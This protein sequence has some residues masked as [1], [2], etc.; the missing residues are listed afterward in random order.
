MRPLT[1]VAPALLALAA[2]A[3][4]AQAPADAVGWGASAE[5]VQRRLV[6]RA[7]NGARLV[8][9]SGP[10][11]RL[12]VDG[13]LAL[14][15]GGALQ[16]KAWGAAGTL[17][18]DGQ[19][20]AGIPL[21]TDSRHRELGLDLAWRP[22]PAAS[23][24]QA[25]LVLR[26]LQQRRDIASTP[27]AVGLV[28]TSDYVM[29]GVRFSHAFDGGGWRWEPSL[30]LLA[31]VRHRLQVDSHGVFDEA[32]IRGG[33]RRELVLGL[34][35][36]APQSPWSLALAWSHARQSASPTQALSRNGTTVGT[37]RQPRVEIDDVGLRVRRAF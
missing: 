23:W 25:W 3:A 19:T 26:V 10:L 4:C 18:Y 20:Q 1:K 29:P 17:D 8:K 14:A 35:V 2:G 30:E 33:R 15:N 7:D 37:V 34:Q 12:A 21:T 32:D 31:S 13:Q 22:L 16:A 5:V 27:V 9:E 6:E 28:E 24:G 11:L 36:S